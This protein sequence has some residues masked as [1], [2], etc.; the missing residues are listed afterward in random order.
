MKKTVLFRRSA[1][2][3]RLMTLFLNMPPCAERFYAH[4]HSKTMTDLELLKQFSEARGISGHEDD[5]RSLLVASLG[6]TGSFTADRNGSVVHTHGSQGPRIM[7]AAHMDEIGF[8][9]Q[10]INADGFLHVVPVGGWWTH[11][12]LSQ[13]VVIAT[14]DGR[15]IP[16]VTGSKPPHFLPESERR[17]LMPIE[18]VFIDVGAS[19]REQAEQEMGIHLGDPVIP[20][21]SFTPLADPNRVM[22]KA[23]DNRAGVAVMVEAARILQREGHPNVLQSTGTVQEEVG[24]RGAKT[25]AASTHPDCAI[26]LEAPPADDTPGFA[27]ADAQGALGKGVQIRLFDPTAITNPR[28]ARLTE[29]TALEHD[30]PYQLT[31]RRSGG[32]DAGAL[33]L[34]EAGIPCIVL[35][36]PTRYIHA[37]NGILDVRD[38]EAAIRLCVALVKKLD[39]P[40]VDSLVR[41]L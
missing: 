17:N 34:A 3:K 10:H 38:Y 2:R 36:V 7:L 1:T 19:S 25:I 31:V 24:T 33:H 26:I 14:R 6:E 37:H 29:E 12:L 13:R 23:F 40:T 18:S 30:I 11:T 15:S 5:V 9:V 20:D 35:G 32:T 41:Y 4:H 8:L 21:V 22:G 39:A 27:K 16:G 28:L